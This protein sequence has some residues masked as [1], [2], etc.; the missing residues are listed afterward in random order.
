VPVVHE[1]D[2]YQ[3]GADREAIGSE[4]AARYLARDKD[5][6]LAIALDAARM[7]HE[8]RM[9]VLRGPSKSGKSRT[10]F[11]AVRAHPHQCPPNRGKSGSHLDRERNR[12]PSGA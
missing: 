9:V 10:L 8:P 6:E 3:L 4:Y 2:A 5:N 1:L 12:R 7:A 11:E